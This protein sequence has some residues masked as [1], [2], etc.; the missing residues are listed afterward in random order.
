MVLA[1]TVVTPMTLAIGVPAPS[2]LAVSWLDPLR[3]PGFGVGSSWQLALW[4][5]ASGLF[6][7][8][9][10][11]SLGSAWPLA[12]GPAPASAPIQVLLRQAKGIGAE[13]ALRM[14][15]RHS[16]GPYRFRSAAARGNT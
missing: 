8:P 15:F 12:T 13:S 14:G 3:S 4:L 5:G 7:A 9:W 11:C 2:A 10:L 16:A 1:L 6:P